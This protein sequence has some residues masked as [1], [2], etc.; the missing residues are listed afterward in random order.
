MCIDSLP[1]AQPDV[2]EERRGPR[3]DAPIPRPGVDLSRGNFALVVIDPQND[4]LSE[5]GVTWGVVGESVKENKTVEHIDALFQAAKKSGIPVFVSPHYYYPHDHRWEFGGAL[6]KMMHAVGMFDREGALKTNGFDG[7]GADWH[8]PLKSL[9]ER[10][11][12]AV[13]KVI[14][15]MKPR[16]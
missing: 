11:K 5:K 6:E 3:A 12:A 14:R 16:S 13:R 1:T 8:E 9:L 15:Q 2:R 10:V 4:F 7:S